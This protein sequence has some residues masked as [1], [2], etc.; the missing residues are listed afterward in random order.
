MRRSQL[1]TTVNVIQHMTDQW[2]LELEWAKSL[3]EKEV[4]QQDVE[5]KSIAPIKPVRPA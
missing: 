1:E 4:A 2:R 5:A 3:R